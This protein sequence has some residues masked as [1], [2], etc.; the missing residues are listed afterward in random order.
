MTREQAQTVEKTPCEIADF[1]QDVIECA[2]NFAAEFCGVD[3]PTK[4]TDN[5]FTACL[6]Y[7]HDRYITDNYYNNKHNVGKEYKDYKIINEIMDIYFYICSLYD[8]YISLMGFVS[9][10]GIDE[11]T[12]INW[13]DKKASSNFRELHKKLLARSEESLTNNL[14]TGRKNPMGNLAILNN[15]FAWSTSNAKTETVHRVESLEDIRQAIGV[16]T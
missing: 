2:C 3:T 5:Q 4:L 15:R 6:I 12:V 14:A 11:N 10:S 9:F 13:S 8:K 7:I 1:R 16:N